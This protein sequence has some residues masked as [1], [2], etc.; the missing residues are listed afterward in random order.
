MKREWG[1]EKVVT[2]LAII[3][4]V[5]AISKIMLNRLYIIMT[6]VFWFLYVS[7]MIYEG[8]I[9][10]SV[11]HAAALEATGYL[12]IVTALCLS[13]LSYL[14]ARGG[15]LT[16]FQRYQRLPRRKLD[17]FFMRNR[18]RLTVLIP[19]YNEEVSVIRKT[20]LS[21]ALQE[22]PDLSI[23]LLIDDDPQQADPV[24]AAKLAATKALIQ[25]I[26]ELL[27]VPCR[28]VLTSR[29]IFQEH[30][31]D[32][33]QVPEES[34]IDLVGEYRFAA[35]W[36]RTLAAAENQQDHVDAFFATEVLVQ[37]AENLLKTARAIEKATEIHKELNYELVRHLYSRLVWIFSVEL[38]Y[39]Q[40]K[41]YL[42]S[43]HEAN[44]AMNLNAYIDLM[45][46]QYQIQKTP[47]GK[48]L[49]KANRTSETDL[50]IPDSE[51]ILTLD[52]DSMLLQEYCLRLVHLLCQPGNEEV[53]VTQTPYSSFRGCPTR[54]ERI[55]GATTDIQHVLHQGM[56]HFDATFWV[57]ANAVIRKKALEE[58]AETD[59][60]RG[61]TI[62]RFIQDMTVIEDT[63]SSIDMQQRGWRL[64]NFPE[65]LS[66]SATPPDFGA[67]IIQRRR[68]ANG[69][70]LIL[71]KLMQTIRKRRFKG[72]PLKGLEILLR[73]NYMASIAWGSIGLLGL[74][75]Y[76]FDEKLLS[77][78]IVGAAGSY[79]LAMGED[80]RY[81]RYH[82]RD[83]FWIY[84]FNLLL[85]PVNLAGIFKSIQ[86]FLTGMKIPF[87]RTPKVADKTLAPTIYLLSPLLIISYS[88]F[89][90][91]QSWQAA[92][93][94]TAAFALGNAITC[95]AAVVAFIGPWE[96]VKNL[97][98]NFINWLFV[99][100]PPTQ[101]IPEEEDLDWQSELYYQ[102][103]YQ[104]VSLVESLEEAKEQTSVERPQVR[105][106]DSYVE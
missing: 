36:L 103:D 7:W 98:M 18:P 44:K 95:G 34:L 38:D 105:K 85:L 6:I 16:R 81:A 54:L 33:R 23:R 58:I 86:Q 102:M 5:P 67:L 92:N 25:E 22:Y 69:G 68:W 77:L 94:G 89:S 70:L 93:W 40:R 91:W 27:D 20:I 48:I 14:I 52:A 90:F 9:W 28:R 31:L 88:L 83:V 4:K 104:R 13:A 35:N 39:F 75:V 55:A 21:A 17:E 99:E 76:P 51:F 96:L 100:V 101:V 80:L 41:E 82:F 49:A 64:V 47:E 29:E 43:S 3:H 53:A 8:R 45:G 61:F 63:E 72:D 106:A 26:Q 66:Y 12:V 19:S 50:T 1:T 11:S 56:T 24:R 59:E 37:L 65:R 42:S 57:G 73:L 71:P 32:Q 78:Y 10:G 15:A 2:P 74:L 46:G 84:G 97:A 87:A 79:F 62:R 60:V 30:Y